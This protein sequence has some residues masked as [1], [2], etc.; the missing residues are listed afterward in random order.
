[1]SWAIFTYQ[2]SAHTP[3]L[4]KTQPDYGFSEGKS[5]LNR[6]YNIGDVH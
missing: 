5:L 2:K 1:M 4:F 3:T 6:S